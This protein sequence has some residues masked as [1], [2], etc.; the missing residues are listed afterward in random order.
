MNTEYIA[1]LNHS[2]GNSTVKANKN[3]SSND[4]IEGPGSPHRELWK[5]LGLTFVI[6]CAIF[7]P[8]IGIVKV[9]ESI[10]Q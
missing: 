3:E 8:I 4:D 10:Y 7:I 9:F 6:Q 5:L 2:L 1:H